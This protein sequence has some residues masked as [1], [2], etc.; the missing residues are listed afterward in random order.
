M[1]N[2]QRESKIFQVQ[3]HQ[4]IDEENENNGPT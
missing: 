1:C 4:M 2:D 3:A